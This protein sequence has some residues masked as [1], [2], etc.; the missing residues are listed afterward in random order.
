M[1][2]VANVRAFALASLLAVAPV[3]PSATAPAPAPANVSVDAQFAAIEKRPAATGAAFDV[4]GLNAALTGIARISFDSSS[5]DAETGATK[6]SNL[7]V[8][9]L[10]EQPSTLFTAKEM[11]VW[12]A[13]VAA[14]K[15]RMNGQRL[16][17]TL[18]LFDRIEL[19]GVNIDLTRYTNALND[20]MSE[21]LPEA[22]AAANI[23]YASSKMT[24]GRVIFSGFTLHP[25]TLEETEGQ[26]EGLAAIRLLSALARSFSLDNSAAFDV[27]LD[28]S[29][30]EGSASGSLSSGSARQLIEGY[31]RGDVASMI[32]T[33]AT[34]SGA[35]P[36]PLLPAR[37]DSAPTVRS[38]PV[39]ISGAS[40]YSAISGIRLSKLLAY[41]ER[42]EMP[43]ITERNLFSLGTY[44]LE[45]LKLDLDG[46][47]YFEIGA[48]NISADQFAWFLP[49]RISIRHQD[50]AFDIDS[51]MAWA[52][53][54]E[55]EGASEAGAPSIQEIAGILDRTGL[56]RLSG[57]G[58]LS[59]TWNSKTGATRLS[60]QSV[61]DNLYTDNTRFEMTLPSYADLVPAFGKDGKTP[62]DAVL[63]KLFQDTFSIVGGEYSFTDTGVLNAVAALTIEIAKMSGEDDAMLA[64][65]AQGTPDTVRMFASGMLM[66]ASGAVTQEVPDAL[67][68]LTGLSQFITA[69]GTFSI[70]IAPERPV[71]LADLTGADASAGMAQAPAP[72]E[73]VSRFGLSMTHTPP[74][75]YGSP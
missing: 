30:V 55:P 9:S 65:F 16:G 27:R 15:S 71:T 34:F 46:N 12:N 35:L 38:E 43:P 57:D 21:A 32:Q 68:W 29:L 4:E 8:D 25:W 10:G 40:A 45:G 54:L 72:A 59:L 14:L 66:F 70:K 47:P 56:G 13:D 58:E 42:G 52:A 74:A 33:G 53:E 24:V 69:G 7:R 22:S 51:L 48:L 19:S 63:Q 2:W 67:P 23:T 64:N 6:L 41:G 49:E 61:S 26:D 60:N 50:V 17:D 28:Q 18:R 37:G 75:G 5:R 62:N 36:V 1:S 44:A 73:L 3:L 11:L 39:E 20:A 31:D